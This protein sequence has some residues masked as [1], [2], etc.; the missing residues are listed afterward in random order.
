MSLSDILGRKIRRPWDAEK[1]EETYQM[2]CHR[3]SSTRPARR[4]DPVSFQK[5]MGEVGR[6]MYSSRFEATISLY[7]PP[8]PP[9][10]LFVPLYA[11]EGLTLGVLVFPMLLLIVLNPRFGGDSGLWGGSPR[12]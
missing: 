2:R 4:F 3:A 10:L 9:W 6:S 1:P 12:A 7:L 5:W 8:R 11:A